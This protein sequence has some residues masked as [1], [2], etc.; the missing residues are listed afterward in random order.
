MAYMG[1]TVSAGRGRLLVTATGMD[2]EMGRIAGVLAAT[3]QGKTP[4]QLKLAALSRSLS[5]LVLAICVFIFGFG[6]WRAGSTDLATVLSSRWR[7]CPRGW[8]RW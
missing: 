6:L 7:R 8:R 2:T 5:A 3:S 4:L 1:S